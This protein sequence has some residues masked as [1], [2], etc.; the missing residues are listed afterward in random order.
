[1]VFAK[2]Y[3]AAKKDSSQKNP[4]NRTQTQQDSQSS[5]SKNS[6]RK[7]HRE[8][9]S[10]NVAKKQRPRRKPKPNKKP[11]EAALLLTSQLKACSNKKLL[12]NA[13]DLYWDP[14]HKPI[15][16]NYH[17]CIAIDCCAR[18]GEMEEAEK[19][20][21]SLTSMSVET[22]T[23]LLKGYVHGGHVK[24]AASLFESMC[25]SKCQAERPNVRT[26]NTMLRGKLC[27]SSHELSL[28]TLVSYFKH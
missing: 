17:A 25:L 16:D 3:E 11:S 27:W 1:M 2:F 19:I 7:R 24:K 14:K 5:P 12:R 15:L 10:D 8:D 13:L 23:C 9:D 21:S 26:L 22:K 6:P 28:G 20:S 4:K 18:C